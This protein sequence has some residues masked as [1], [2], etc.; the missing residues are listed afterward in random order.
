MHRLIEHRPS[1]AMVV[2]CVAL[3][4]ALGGT[5][6]AAVNAIAAFMALFILKPMRARQI[7]EDT[8]QPMGKLVTE[9]AD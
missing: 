8:R 3:V 2:A 1:P 9:G 5:G 6:V 4:V 7:A